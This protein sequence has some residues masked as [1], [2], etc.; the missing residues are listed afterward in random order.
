MN[1][2]KVYRKRYECIKSY[3]VIRSHILRLPNNDTRH[4]HSIKLKLITFQGF[5]SLVTRIVMRPS[6][7][8]LRKQ[9]IT[10]HIPYLH[11]STSRKQDRV[12]RAQ[13]GMQSTILCTIMSG[14]GSTFLPRGSCRPPHHKEG[15]SPAR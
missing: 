10:S 13:A 9:E 8:R 4:S 12:E 1:E 14:K 3:L 11:L 5:L 7:V 6:E 15:S 2:V